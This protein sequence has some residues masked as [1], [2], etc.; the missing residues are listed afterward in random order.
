[1]LNF[2]DRALGTQDV[3]DIP[4]ADLLDQL[5]SFDENKGL[6]GLAEKYQ[7]KKL[8]NLNIANAD[9]VDPIFY[10]VL[11]ADTQ[12]SFEGIVN[13]DVI[14]EKFKLERLRQL[15]WRLEHLG[16]YAPNL[17]SKKFEEY[18]QEKSVR[19]PDDLIA[20]MEFG[21]DYSLRTNLAQLIAQDQ[22][23][24]PKTTSIATSNF[25]NAL[26]DFAEQIREQVFEQEKTIPFVLIFEMIRTT[27]LNQICDQLQ[28]EV[29]FL[30]EP[31]LQSALDPYIEGIERFFF[32]PISTTF[33]IERK[34]FFSDAH[35]RNKER[36]RVPGH[37]QYVNKKKMRS[38]FGKQNRLKKIADE[39]SFPTFKSLVNLCISL[40]NVGPHVTVE[41]WY[42]ID[43][44]VKQ[45]HS[46]QLIAQ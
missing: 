28:R 34:A 43:A 6:M 21:E 36:R 18:L 13:P 31:E 32:T 22:S 37:K 20:E 14:E 5:K 7:K 44:I 39:S 19:M 42:H 17:S 12:Q 8:A 29:Q 4:E 40:V 46:T 38:F 27:L 30:G 3:R 10:K 33:Q 25:E 24:P 1:M 45:P 26:N 9:L 11:L 15:S 2:F 23:K 35:M 16:A 41:Y